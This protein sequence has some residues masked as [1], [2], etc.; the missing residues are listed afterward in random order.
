[1]SGVVGVSDVHI[2]KPEE[3]AGRSS[4]NRDGSWSPPPPGGGL[5]QSPLLPEKS[6]NFCHCSS[7]GALGIR[8]NG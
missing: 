1:M 3:G 7:C 5:A 2:S 4:R 6:V 8:R